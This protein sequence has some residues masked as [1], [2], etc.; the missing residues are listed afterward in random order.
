MRDLSLP[1]PLRRHERVVR[2]HLHAEPAGAGGDQL[3]DAPEAEHAQRLPAQLHASEAR[4][5]PAAV[6]QRGVR[7]RDVAGQRQQQPDRVLRGR[8]HVRAGCVGHDDAAPRGLVHVHV[9][10]PGTCPA[11]H[12]QPRRT[13]QHA[14]VDAGLAAHD[15]RVVVADPV[16]QLIR[17]DVQL[18]VDVE[19]VGQQLDAGLGD[20]LR[21][22]H[23]GAVG[24][25]AHGRPGR[26]GQLRHGWSRAARTPPPPA[27][28]RRLRS[29]PGSRA[30]P[31]PAP[32]PT[33][34]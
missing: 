9:V 18:D 30:R 16:A 6:H 29:A 25:A 23:P 24:A 21:D 33:A 19:P 10:D 2:D 5:L 8:H 27:P 4:A 34:R 28:P 14:G 12:L 13:P 32:A 7:L 20:L 3:A 26:L 15:Q 31:A 11:H 17:G 1:E 22:Q